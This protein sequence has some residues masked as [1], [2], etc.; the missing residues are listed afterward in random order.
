MAV[1]TRPATGTPGPWFRTLCGAITFGSSLV[2]VFSSL[3]YPTTT[4]GSEQLTIWG[5]FLWGAGLAVGGAWLI[6]GR[7]KGQDLVL[8]RDRKRLLTVAAMT[9]LVV[10]LAVFFATLP[11]GE[12]ST[13]DASLGYRTMFANLFASLP[14]LLFDRQEHPERTAP[15]PQ[16]AV[17]RGKVKRRIWLLVLAGVVAWPAGL[18]LG[19]LVHPWFEEILPQ[20]GTGL[21]AGA[22]VLGYRLRKSRSPGTGPEASPSR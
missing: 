11:A 8:V 16:D 2:C 13:F 6:R 17:G 20:L 21:L 7:S 12:D 10:G 5:F 9:V 22:A 15:L 1:E 3:P 14:L 19:E 4:S 18:V